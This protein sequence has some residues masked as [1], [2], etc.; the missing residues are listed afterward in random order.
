MVKEVKK[1]VEQITSINQ[2]HPKYKE[3]YISPE[4]RPKKED[5]GA[6]ACK[7]DI[8]ES[9]IITQNVLPLFQREGYR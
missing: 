6:N 2:D 3:F 5:D 4:H 7:T 1:G 9:Y 8:V